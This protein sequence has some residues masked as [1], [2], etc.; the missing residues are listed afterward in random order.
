MRYTKKTE[1]E[2]NEMFQIRRGEATKRYEVFGGLK[3]DDGNGMSE[4]CF[5]DVGV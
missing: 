5:D 1:F 4:V 2:T 3:G